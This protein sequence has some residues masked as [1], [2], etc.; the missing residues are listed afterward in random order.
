MKV[1]RD[2]MP[3]KINDTFASRSIVVDYEVITPYGNGLDFCW[4]GLLRGKT[5]IERISRISTE[6]FL[7]DNAA[8]INGLDQNVDE[9]L[10]M[11]MLKNLFSYR[12]PIIPKD[13]CLFLATTTG[14]IDLLEKDI[15][16]GKKNSERSSLQ[17]FLRKVEKLTGVKENSGVLISAACA[18]S[19]VAIAKAAMMISTG[20]IDCA[21]IVACDCVSEFVFSGFSGLMAL[22]DSIS[23][24]FDKNRNGLSLGEAAGYILLMNEERTKRESI[25]NLGEVAGWG[26]SSDAYHM[27]GP[28]PDGSGLVSAIANALAKSEL[29]PDD[30]CCI[31]AHGTGTVYNDAMEIKAFKSVFSNRDI[32]T[33][34]IKGGTGH[35]LAAA[36]LLETIITLKSLN[37]KIILPTVNFSKP[38]D[39]CAGS[40]ISSEKR[41]L[42]HNKY[43]LKVNAGFGGINAALILKHIK[44]L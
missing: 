34:S 1:K 10:V 14:E 39:D 9:S 42:S 26:F 23:K 37:E 7:T 27:T 17:N 33:F 22:S 8:I 5:A 25:N 44:H 41:Y 6:N 38:D 11:Q 31:S 18:S 28:S 13:A 29:S 40:W 15:L 3:L 4:N 43:A 24:P 12:M 20:E 32:P 21:L 19:T 30:I 35:T 36:G 2:C 16:K